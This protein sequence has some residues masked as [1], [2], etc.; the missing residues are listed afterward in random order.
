MRDMNAFL[1]NVKRAA[2]EAVL[3]MK[4]FSFVLGTVSSAS[5]LKIRVDQKLELS[6]PQLVLTNA[7][8]DHTV[9]ITVDHDTEQTCRVHLALKTGEQVLL[10]RT[11]GGQ[12]YIVLDRAEAP[13]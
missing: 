3:A 13:T 11:D 1:A 12:K 2:I 10:L 5:P 7:V 8:R 9:A 4:P 6:A